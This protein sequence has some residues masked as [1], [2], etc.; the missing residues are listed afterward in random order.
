MLH[1]DVLPYVRLHL[2][3]V[4][5]VRTLE[6]RFLTALVTQVTGQVPLPSENAST[7]RIRTGELVRFHEPRGEPMTRRRQQRSLLP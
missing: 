7:V 5:A 6:P 2:A 4:I 3:Q 1:P